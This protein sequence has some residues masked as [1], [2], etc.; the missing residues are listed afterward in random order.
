MDWPS[1][2]PD[3][4]LVEHVWDQMV[5]HIHDIDNLQTTATQLRV[6]VQQFGIAC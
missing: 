1:K 2:S 4:N 6:A 3:M 5:V